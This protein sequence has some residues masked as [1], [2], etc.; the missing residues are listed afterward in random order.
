MKNV[1]KGKLLKIYIGESD[2]WHGEPL[3]HAIIKKMKKNGLAGATIL[4]GIEGFGANSCVHSTKILRLSKD[5]PIVIEVV[6]KEEKINSMI[7][8]LDGMIKE[9]LIISLQ[10]IEM[11]KY[12]CNKDKKNSFVKMH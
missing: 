10:D 12:S 2:K 6:D 5:L 4:R 11:I 1:E 9:G 8:I 7:D 3:Y